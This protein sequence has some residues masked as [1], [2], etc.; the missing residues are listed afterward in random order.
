MSKNYDAIPFI[1]RI[2]RLASDRVGGTAKLGQHLGLSQAEL[3]PY[4]LGEAIPPLHALLK[5]V[6]LVIEHVNLA[7]RPWQSVLQAYQPDDHHR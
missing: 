1:Q 5:A 6:E 7:E 3:R 2:F 4:L